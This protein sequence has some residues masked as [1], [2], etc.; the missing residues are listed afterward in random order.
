MVHLQ[1]GACISST[2]VK[3]NSH[4]PA[5]QT[6]DCGGRLCIC[7]SHTQEARKQQACRRE[8]TG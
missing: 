4:R 2:I 3:T 7:G 5:A 6:Q 1:V 8:A